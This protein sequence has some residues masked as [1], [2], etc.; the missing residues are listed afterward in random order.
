MSH[1]FLLNQKQL[2]RIKRVFAKPC[3][4]AWSDESTV[5]GDVIQVMRK[6]QRR[7]DARTEQGFD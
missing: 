4:V 1:P 5:H 7:R 6:G 3:G 2:K